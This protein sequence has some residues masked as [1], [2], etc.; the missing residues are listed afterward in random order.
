MIIHLKEN[1]SA[2]DAKII[3]EKVQGKLIYNKVNKLIITSS[4]M[5]TLKK[6]IENHISKK[7]ILES[8]I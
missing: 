6:E 8:D 5:T 3:S 7:Y 1:I 2:A 4:K